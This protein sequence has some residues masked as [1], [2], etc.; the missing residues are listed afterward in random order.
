MVDTTLI[1]L[2]ADISCPT[3]SLAGQYIVEHNMKYLDKLN[4]IVSTVQTKLIE[5]INK[6]IGKLND[7]MERV[8]ISRY[9]IATDLD[10]RVHSI[11]NYISSYISTKIKELT[12]IETSIE[13]KYPINKIILL[14]SSNKE[15]ISS[16]KFQQLLNKSMPFTIIWNNVKVVVSNYELG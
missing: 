11:S 13:E 8:T 3:P 16:D 15:I 9:N 10:N 5:S 6:N 1:D 7:I 2:V 12:F 14:N 4:K